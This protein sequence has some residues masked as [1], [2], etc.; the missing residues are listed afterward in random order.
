MNEMDAR[1]QN[2]RRLANEPL[3]MA[4][5]R[6]RAERTITKI[7]LEKIHGLIDRIN[8]KDNIY[9]DL[10][11]DL[12]N[13]PLSGNDVRNLRKS[14]DEIQRILGQ[15][16]NAGE[17]TNQRSTILMVEKKWPTSISFRILD[18]KA[19]VLAE[20]R[21]WTMSKLIQELESSIKLRESVQ[22]VSNISG[23]QAIKARNSRQKHPSPASGQKIFQRYNAWGQPSPPIRQSQPSDSPAFMDESEGFSNLGK[24]PKGWIP[25]FHRPCNMCQAKNEGKANV[26]VI[27]FDE[28]VPYEFQAL[29]LEDIDLYDIVDGDESFYEAPNLEECDDSSRDY[30]LDVPEDSHMDD[31]GY[32]KSQKI[33]GEVLLTRIYWH[34]RFSDLR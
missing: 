14:L 17:D 7:D 3:D 13:L 11:N 18:K 6:L 28:T 32:R 26:H 9:Q 16:E 29:D 31:R 22:Q 4:L 8:Y 2:P 34:Q 33:A 19:Q 10:Y 30:G 27:N 1:I 20:A 5:N 24:S 15:L 21:P 12:E 23:E 25:K